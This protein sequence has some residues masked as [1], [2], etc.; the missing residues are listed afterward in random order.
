MIKDKQ[1]DITQRQKHNLLQLQWYI[2]IV[3]LDEIKIEELTYV[4]H[5]GTY[6]CSQYSGI[7]S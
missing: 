3:S 6:M 7:A 1:T 2:E 4:V 5:L